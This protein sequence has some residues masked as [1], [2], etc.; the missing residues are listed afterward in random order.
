LKLNQVK[1]L[2]IINIIA[3]YGTRLLTKKLRNS[4]TLLINKRAKSWL[5]RKPKKMLSR[6]LKNKKLR[7]LM[8]PER[9]KS[10]L[11]RIEKNLKTKL[12]IL[13]SFTQAWYQ[14]IDLFN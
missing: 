8:K 4:K 10:R 1:M 6:E 9:S 7:K 11:K 2:V 5:R 14:L 13:V 3:N 12:I